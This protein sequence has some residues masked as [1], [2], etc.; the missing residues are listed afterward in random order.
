MCNNV[1]TSFQSHGSLDQ[2]SAQELTSTWDSRPQPRRW[3]Q[4]LQGR[5]RSDG[6]HFDSRLDSW[7][8]WS[9][10]L[11]PKLRAVSRGWRWLATR[12]KLPSPEGSRISV[13]SLTWRSTTLPDQNR[14]SLVLLLHIVT[15]CY[16]LLR[17]GGFKLDFIA[18]RDVGT[19]NFKT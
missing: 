6:S 2:P 18:E 14:V 16:T 5:G 4:H 3:C 11:L 9:P 12:T 17:T 1:T 10:Y 7:T 15:H 8:G 19:L 13:W